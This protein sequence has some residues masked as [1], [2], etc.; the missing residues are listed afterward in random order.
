MTVFA[1]FLSDV[2]SFKEFVFVKI[3]LADDNVAQ[4][5]LGCGGAERGSD[6]AAAAP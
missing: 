2:L 5:L 1:N 6:G 4:A 3:C